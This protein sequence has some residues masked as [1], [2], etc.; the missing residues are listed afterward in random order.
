MLVLMK[1]FALVKRCLQ[2]LRSQ[3]WGAIPRP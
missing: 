3:D 2:F 1:S